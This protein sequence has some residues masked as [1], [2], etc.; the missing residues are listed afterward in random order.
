MFSLLGAIL[1]AFGLATNG[2]EK[3]YARSLGINANL[4]WGLVLLAFGLTMFIFGKR[5]RSGRRNCRQKKAKRGGGI[6]KQGT[7]I[8]GVDARPMSG[9]GASALMV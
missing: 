6:E 4:W 1:S 8:K 9:L 5:G 7:G 2:N 3:L